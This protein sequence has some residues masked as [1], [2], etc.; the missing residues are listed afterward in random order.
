LS[1]KNLAGLILVSPLTSGKEQAKASGLTSISF[2]AGRSFSNIDKIKNIICPVLV[3]HGTHDRVIPY[4]MGIKIYESLQTQKKIIAIYEAGHNN[5]SVDFKREYWK[6][7][8]EF[9]AN[10]L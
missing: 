7:V 5:I 6:S 1:Q 10:G 4:M 8:E 3:I 2:L 9:L